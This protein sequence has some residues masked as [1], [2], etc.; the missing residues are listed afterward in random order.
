MNDADF[1]VRAWS[2]T[3][4]TKSDWI[5]TAFSRNDSL[6]ISNPNFHPNQRGHYDLPRRYR[7]HRPHRAHALL[8]CYHERAGLCAE[9]LLSRTLVVGLGEAGT[10]RPIVGLVSRLT[11]RR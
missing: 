4:E 9:V 1:C 5:P 7:H 2:V 11:A 10:V 6:N 8:L 3:F